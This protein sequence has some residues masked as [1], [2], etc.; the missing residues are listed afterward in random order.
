VKVRILGTAAGGG[1]P[2]WN[3]GCEECQWARETGRHR[4]QD[5]LA[6]TGDEATWYLFNASP[7]LRAQLIA[8]PELAPSPGSRIS[9]IGG[10]LLTSAELDHTLGLLTLREADAITV[11]ATETTR[12][13][14]PYRSALSA[15]TSVD[16]RVV[17]PS[18]PLDLAGGLVVTAFA[19]GTKR[20]RYASEVTV[21]HWSVA[22]R[23]ADPI[24]GGVLVYAPGLERWTPGFTEGIRGADVVLLDGTFAASVELAASGTMGH[25]SIADS[26]PHVRSI[27]GPR[28]FYTH[29]NNTNPFGRDQPSGLAA[30]T[31]AGAGIARDGDL[32]S[33]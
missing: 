3:C 12:D 1:L 32:L 9:P 8:Y 31:E 24:S 18:E 25:L 13:A 17:R 16:W 2:Q 10:V 19:P 30:L 7:D 4:L 23:I 29:L 5:G 26:L 27:K 21:G 22:Y 28:F 15:Y 33:L 14:V 11:W 20:P 6:V